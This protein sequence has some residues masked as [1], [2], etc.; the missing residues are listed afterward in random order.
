MASVKA[1]VKIASA[2][3]LL[4]TM[5]SL[6]AKGKASTDERNERVRLLVRG[7][8]E[9]YGTITAAAK[10]IGVEQPT[11]SDLLSKKRGAGIELLDALSR[12]T[13]LSLD[14]IVRGVPLG[15]HAGIVAEVLPSAGSMPGW[16]DCVLEARATYPD[17]P[18]WAW[19]VAGAL[20]PPPGATATPE[21]AAHLAHLAWRY[22][23]AS[24]RARFESDA[25]ARGL[26]RLPGAPRRRAK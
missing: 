1:L 7:L 16:G 24:D 22:T 2:I 18:A 23:G 3:Y 20:V 26:A 17:V 12:V 5:Y 14:E 19:D 15:A 9:R 21:L 4:V 11:L 25:Q 8:V 10:A 13:R 6:M